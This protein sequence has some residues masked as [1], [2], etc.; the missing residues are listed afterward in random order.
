LNYS[1][2]L[3]LFS[4][5]LFILSPAAIPGAFALT[6]NDAQAI[7]FA[8]GDN[9][10]EVIDGSTATGSAEEAEDKAAVGAVA[11]EAAQSPD[12]LVLSIQFGKPDK[13]SGVQEFQ[14][15][16]GDT[17]FV[18]TSNADVNQPTPQE[19][20]EQQAYKMQVAKISTQI[21]NKI[22]DIQEKSNE[23]DNQ[24]FI[25][26]RAPLANEKRFMQ[27]DLRTLQQ[28]RTQLEARHTA[29]EA[30]KP[31]PTPRPTA[32]ATGINVTPSLENGQATIEIQTQDGVQS[33]VQAPPGKWVQIYASPE[34]GDEIWAKVDLPA[35]SPN[36]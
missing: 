26:H 13:G 29:R 11:S 15:R 10:E 5:I 25:A 22:S 24:I 12:R 36:P 18:Q 9:V 32:V 34:G 3:L 27:D 8:Q 35:P 1:H 4:S 16:N 19:K 7:Q 2:I 21:A 20:E 33:T 14:L 6:L 30:L 31:P 17:A 23:L 28:E